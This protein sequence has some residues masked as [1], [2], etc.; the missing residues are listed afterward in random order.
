V[1]DDSTASTRWTVTRIATVLFFTSEFRWTILIDLTFR[2]TTS[3]V[4]IADEALWADTLGAVESDLTVRIGST[5]LK[6]AWALTLTVDTSLIGSTLGISRA[7]SC[8][9]LYLRI[10]D[11]S[12]GTDTNGSVL[13]NSADGIAGANGRSLDTRINTTL[14]DTGL[15]SLTIPIHFAF[16]FNDGFDTSGSRLTTNEWIAGVSIGAGADWIVTDNLA[17]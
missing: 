10:T 6:G 9:T 14:F 16:R 17:T 15:G 4:R 12:F 3:L 2:L 5:G 7:S 13:D 11:E 1:I 8:T